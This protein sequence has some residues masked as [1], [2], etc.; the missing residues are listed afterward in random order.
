MVTVHGVL[1]MLRLFWRQCVPDTIF[2]VDVIRRGL[3]I[4]SAAVMIQA[5][6]TKDFTVASC[7]WGHRNLIM[8]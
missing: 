7:F 2:T 1:A 8:P 6:E 4:A 5:E 3:I